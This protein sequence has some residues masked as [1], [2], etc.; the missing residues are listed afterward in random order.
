MLWLY[1]GTRVHKT[2]RL[3]S[4]VWRFGRSERCDHYHF[5][6]DLPLLQTLKDKHRP[7]RAVNNEHRHRTGAVCPIARP[8][9]RNE[10]YNNKKWNGSVVRVPRRLR[11]P[12]GHGSIGTPLRWQGRSKEINAAPNHRQRTRLWLGRVERGG[13]DGR[14]KGASWWGSRQKRVLYK[15]TWSNPCAVG[16]RRKEA[17]GP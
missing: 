5:I 16:T 14:R 7:W 13:G 12:T 10:S 11:A 17:S 8:N 1:P 6:H 15:A 2:D 4:S 9:Q 3:H